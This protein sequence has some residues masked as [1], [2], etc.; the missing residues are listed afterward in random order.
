MS[1]WTKEPSS[2]KPPRR[3]PEG[4]GSRSLTILRE[5]VKRGLRL[6]KDGSII[7]PS[8][9]RTRGRQGSGRYPYRS[10]HIG[11]NGKHCKVSSARVICYLAHGEPPAPH[12]LADHIN[13]D[14]LDDRPENLRWATYA[15]NLCNGEA[16]RADGVSPQRVQE[17]LAALAGI[18]DPAAALK[19][20]REALRGVAEHLENMCE[21]DC[22]DAAKCREA[23]ALIGGGECG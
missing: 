16:N 6:A 22:P 15:D 14:P 3:I 12:Y 21:P 5:S 11:A 23:L 9:R 7:L 20:A 8:G 10:V 19:A 2:A 1:S 17:C 13:G 4:Y 18:P